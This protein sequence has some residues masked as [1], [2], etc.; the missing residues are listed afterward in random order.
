MPR[1]AVDDEDRVALNSMR[2]AS[3]HSAGA[4]ARFL[5][6]SPA[7]ATTHP[8]GSNGLMEASME[9]LAVPLPPWAMRAGARR[10]IFFNPAE[11]RAG[12]RVCVPARRPPAS[13][14]RGTAGRACGGEPPSRLTLEP[15]QGR[16]RQAPRA[17]QERPVSHS[18]R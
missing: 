14:Q 18:C 7:A 9:Q 11:V 4:T 5:L 10:E 15:T 16:G 8:D 1:L 3:I 13:A 17:H 2:F 12:E 6:N